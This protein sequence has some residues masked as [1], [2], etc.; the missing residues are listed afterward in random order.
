MTEKDA[1]YERWNPNPS[2]KGRIASRHSHLKEENKK[3]YVLIIK[4]FQGKTLK[5]FC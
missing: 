1:K 4:A 2:P 3:E 5:D